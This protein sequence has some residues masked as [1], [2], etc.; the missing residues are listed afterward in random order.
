METRP[1]I[2]KIRDGEKTWRCGCGG[3]LATVYGRVLCL[4][5]GFSRRPDD[6]YAKTQRSRSRSL[7]AKRIRNMNYYV[8]TAPDG[9]ITA[10]MGSP[11]F[12]LV[13]MANA[14]YQADAYVPD[15]LTKKSLP[16]R[17]HCP[18]C[19]KICI[20]PSVYGKPE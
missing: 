4:P 18:S 19:H 11:T 8:Q 20:I 17:V 16:A 15:P 14:S 13:H 3:R 7:N 6:V 12:S 1:A 5:P 2:F 10:L 9:E